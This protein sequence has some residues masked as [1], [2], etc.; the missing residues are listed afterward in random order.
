MADAQKTAIVT[1]ASQGIGAG[2]VEAFARRG[3]SVVANSRNIIKV[4]PFPA[5]SNL[6]LVAGDISDPSTAAKIVDTAVS[7]FGRIDVL[8]NNAGIYFS[9]HFTD[10]T[11]D[12]LRS[13]VSRFAGSRFRQ[14][15]RFSFRHPAC[16]QANVGSE[17]RWKHSQYLDY[18][19]RS[20]DRRCERCGSDDHERRPRGRHA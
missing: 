10:Y 5:S 16:D 13:L 1:G 20:P 19:G 3:Y 2:L 15:R 11:L 12:D 18:A 8:V 7:R 6:A 17:D 9:K 4:N 14:H